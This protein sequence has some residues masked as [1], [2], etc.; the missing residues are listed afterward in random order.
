[1]RRGPW[2]GP[3]VRS[4][5]RTKCWLII[6]MCRM[7]EAIQESVYNPRIAPIRASGTHKCVFL[8]Q[9]EAKTTKCAYLMKKGFNYIDF[10]LYF[11]IKQIY[12][13]FNESIKEKDLLISNLN[14]CHAKFIKSALINTIYHLLTQKYIPYHYSLKRLYHSYESFINVLTHGF[15]TYQVQAHFHIID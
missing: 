14:L 8:A 6:S 7:N 5:L 3:N 2:R 9:A 1:M 12:Y 11:W 13:C 4:G 10:C 15:L